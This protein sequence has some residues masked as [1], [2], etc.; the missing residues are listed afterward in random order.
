MTTTYQA[1]PPLR[2]LYSQPISALAFD[3]VSDILWTGNSIGGIVALYGSRGDRG[4]A[5]RV[6]GDLPVKKILVGDNYVRATGSA[7]IGVGSWGK[8]G[9]NNWYFR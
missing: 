7:G 3:P 9:I 8:G 6:G 5:F 2:Q 4:V 1:L